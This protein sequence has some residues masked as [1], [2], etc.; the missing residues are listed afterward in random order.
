MSINNLSIAANLLAEKL[1]TTNRVLAT[2]ESCTG[3][4]VAKVLTDIDGSSRWFEQ[5]IV[6]YSNQAKTN[7]LGVD[8]KMIETHGAVSAEVVEA[9][10]AGLIDQN[11]VID[12]A[13][14]VSGIAGPGGGS[15]EKPVGLV[16][17]GWCLRGELVTSDCQ[18][19]LGDREAVRR[20]AVNY[21]LEGLL[22][23]L[24]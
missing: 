18:F 12:A 9:M 21:V 4:W 11:N 2:A 3:G 7:L 19:F 8:Q 10:A 5:G 20:Q 16:W 14:S 6:S 24:K 15:K 22:A 1:L 23:R 17:F 13:L